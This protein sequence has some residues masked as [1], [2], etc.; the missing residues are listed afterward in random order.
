[1]PFRRLMAFALMLSCAHAH[2]AVRDCHRLLAVASYRSSAELNFERARELAG[3]VLDD[4]VWNLALSPGERDAV[5][6]IHRN[7]ESEGKELVFVPFSQHPEAFGGLD[8]HRVAA[9]GDDVGDPVYVNTE[10]IMGYTLDQALGILI[11]EYGHHAGIKDDE[12]R[13][14]D[15]IAE[16]IVRAAKFERHAL[17]ESLGFLPTASMVTFEVTSRPAHFHV[18][19]RNRRDIGAWSRL[20]REDS[21]YGTHFIVSDGYHEFDVRELIASSYAASGKL[22]YLSL[23]PKSW[24]VD[25]ESRGSYGD[26]ELVI[27]V[28]ASFN[29]EATLQNYLEIRI[30]LAYNVYGKY[31]FKTWMPAY[32]PEIPKFAPYRNQ[33]LSALSTPLRHVDGELQGYDVVLEDRG[34]RVEV[35]MTF[36]AKMKYITYPWP[37]WGRVLE[38][39]GEQM[40][41][42]LPES[43]PL[44]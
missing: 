11:H 1:M 5:I 17:D 10:A 26:P 2:A 30:P 19:P 8:A 9:T 7:L 32:V 13:T 24:S 12:A 29:D 33:V 21:G 40:T 43:H 37:F 23:T 18:D 42:L 15:A 22:H 28:E 25:E 38:I 44:M 3:V 39:D 35:S 31:L 41:G 16:K 34:N 27:G 36:D 4:A 14:L 20:S 6:E